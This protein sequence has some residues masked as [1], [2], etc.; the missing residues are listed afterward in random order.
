[1]AATRAYKKMEGLMAK[2]QALSKEADQATIWQKRNALATAWLEKKAALQKKG[3]DVK[4]LDSWIKAQTKDDAD[5]RIVITHQSA[6]ALLMSIPP[7]LSGDVRTEMK[8]TRDFIKLDEEYD[9][10][11]QQL[12]TE[13]A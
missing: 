8:M 2:K 5:K 9:A 6:A 11:Q 13:L 3:K 1:S 4:W 7:S 10:R 12:N